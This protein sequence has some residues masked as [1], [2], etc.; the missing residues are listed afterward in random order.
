MSSKSKLVLGIVGA[1]AAGV[2]VG[3]LLAPEKGADTRKKIADTASS[4]TD[5]LSDLFSSAKD[6][7]SNLKKQGSKA[8]SEAANRDN[9]VKESYS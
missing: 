9:E 4:W 6:E 2:I 1:A 3:L 8:A 5:H 7:I